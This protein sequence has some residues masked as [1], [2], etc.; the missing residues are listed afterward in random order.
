MTLV[1]S[2]WDTRSPCCSLRWWRTSAERWANGR[3]LI[4]RRF[5]L[6]PACLILKYSLSGPGGDCGRRHEGP[7]PHPVRTD[8]HLGKRDA[9]TQTRPCNALHC[10]DQTLVHQIIETFRANATGRLSQRS[11]APDTLPWQW[12]NPEKP[13]RSNRFDGLFIS[14]LGR[15]DAVFSPGCFLQIGKPQEDGVAPGRPEGNRVATFP[16]LSL[17][18]P[19]L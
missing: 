6:I 12:R 9:Q 4:L 8:P 3:P 2:V 18:S 19:L 17:P 15:F 7:G 5:P 11:L 14:Y 1:A 10:P 16:Y 13:T